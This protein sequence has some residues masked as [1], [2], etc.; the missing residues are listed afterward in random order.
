MNQD[1]IH[2]YLMPGMA[3]SPRIFEYIKLSEE[4]FR[5]HYLE[6]V[7]PIDNECLSDYALRISHKIKH[8]DCVLIGVSFGGVLVQEISKHITYRKLII[9]SS[10]KSMH[11]LPKHMLLAKMTKAYKLLP[12]KLATNI[13]AFSKYAFG[14]NVKKRLEL[15]KRYMSVNDSKY[16]SW[17]IEQMVNWNQ[18]T[19]IPNIIHIHGEKDAVFPIKNID[20]CI[21]VKNGTHIMILNKYKWFN[22]QLPNII[23]SD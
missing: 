21:T 4:R 9:V 22:E 11:E 20:K 13:D 19:I 3:A 5:I 6:W 18:E 15:Y 23:L 10:V 16:L 14:D 8:P 17:A 2:V 12:T 1:I 7:I